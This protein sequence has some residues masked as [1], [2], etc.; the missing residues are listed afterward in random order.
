MSVGTLETHQDMRRDNN[1]KDEKGLQH[2][3]T[4]KCAAP[5]V[6]HSAQISW[7]HERL[8]FR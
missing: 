1:S 4:S 8:I 5:V 6:L 7:R 2:E 3:Q